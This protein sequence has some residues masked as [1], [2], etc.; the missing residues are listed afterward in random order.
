MEGGRKGESEGE[1]VRG[2][3]EMESKRA[4]KTT[5]C[6]MDL[7]IAERTPLPPKKKNA[8]LQHPLKFGRGPA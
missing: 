2:E 7:T 1:M 3:M 5:T 4:N 8:W 6:F